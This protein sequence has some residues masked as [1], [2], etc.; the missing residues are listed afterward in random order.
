MRAEPP[1]EKAIQ[2]GRQQ[3]F[4]AAVIIRGGGLCVGV[5]W[6]RRRLGV[7]VLSRARREGLTVIVRIII[8]VVVII[9]EGLIAVVLYIIKLCPAIFARFARFFRAAIRTFHDIIYYIGPEMVFQGKKRFL[10]NF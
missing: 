8:V 5:V 10:I 7:C 3:A 4:I 1:Q 6:V 9:C 2:K